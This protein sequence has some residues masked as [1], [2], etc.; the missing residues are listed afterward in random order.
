MPSEVGTTDCDAAGL[1]IFIGHKYLYERGVLH[2]DISPGN[3]L[4][5]WRPGSETDQCSTS[6]CLIDLDHAKR[7]KLIQDQVKTSVDDAMI[8]RVQTAIHATTDV[9]VD[10]EVAR[11]SL[12]VSQM[13][14][15]KATAYLNS[16][17][18]HALMFRPL[19]D[20]LCTPEHLRWKQVREFYFR[21]L[22]L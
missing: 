10:K 3:I 4:I 19:T 8:R 13:N 12:E 7:G 21:F 15:P 2:R 5:E 17:L 9:E 14:R 16:A 20:Q 11:L 22:S 6:G 18:D 1:T